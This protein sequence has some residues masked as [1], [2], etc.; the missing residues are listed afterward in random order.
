MLTRALERGYDG[1]GSVLVQPLLPGLDVFGEL[2]IKVV[3]NV[4][5]TGSFVRLG[6]VYRSRMIDVRVSNLKLYRRACITVAEIT[7]V[8]I[9]QQNRKAGKSSCDV[10]MALCL[11][12]I[13]ESKCTLLL[14]AVENRQTFFGGL[15]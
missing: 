1:P 14:P 7:G 8:S 11:Y 15:Q 13:C 12:P 2:A 9:C 3:L 6:K 4:V 5:T 10:G